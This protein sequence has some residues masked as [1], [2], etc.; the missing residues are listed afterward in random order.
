M[1]TPDSHPTN[2]HS[3]WDRIYSPKSVL[4]N[5]GSLARDMFTDL[6]NAREL[7]WRLFLRNISAAYRRTFLGYIWAFLPPVFTTLTF[8]FLQKQK[9]LTLDSGDLPYVVFVLSGTLLWQT[10]FE[11]LNAPLKM[12]NQSKVMLAKINFPREALIL[13]GIAE[14]VFNLWI[15]MLLLVPVLLYFGCMPDLQWLAALF[16][17]FSLI[18]VGTTLGVLILPFGILYEDVE[19]GLPMIATI[20]MFLTPVVYAL[21]TE[22]AARWLLFL[23]PASAPIVQTRDW[24]TGQASGAEG[25]LFL[26]TGIFLAGSFLGWLLYR[27]SLPHLIARLPS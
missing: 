27:V 2:P 18:L 11:A 15:R 13:A 8:L 19:K 23:N 26:I 21:P 7:A 9:V 16:G 5:P 10:F 12:A 3:N 25:T 17:V 4:A 20:W 1:D 22:G 6:L 14:V 24:L